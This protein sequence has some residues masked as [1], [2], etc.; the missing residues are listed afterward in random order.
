[1]SD[2]KVTTTGSEALQVDDGGVQLDPAYDTLE[3]REPITTKT[4]IQTTE[5]MGR[6]PA[7]IA[8]T[9]EDNPTPVLQLREGGKFLVRGKTV[10]TDTDVYIALK[11]WLLVARQ[12]AKKVIQAD[13]NKSVQVAYVFDV[14]TD[15]DALK[16]FNNHIVNAYED[17]DLTDEP[18]VIYTFK[19]YRDQY[20]LAEF[21]RGPNY[22]RAI[23]DFG[24]WLRA[25]HKYAPEGM[26]DGEYELL[27]KIWEAWCENLVDN[28]A[29]AE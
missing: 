23:S 8:F 20:E 24:E 27:D 9:L 29:V 18:T 13:E 5:T 22:G 10:A 28:D 1:M 2:I 6:E 21:Q 17:D 26:P 11:D 7:E 3:I 15:R 4:S 16:A 14:V 25:K 19:A 12:E